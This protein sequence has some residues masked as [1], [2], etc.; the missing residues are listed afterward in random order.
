MIKNSLIKTLNKGCCVFWSKTIKKIME[1]KFQRQ[2]KQIMFRL[3]NWL[4]FA[5]FAD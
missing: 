3:T 1:K 5:Q 4:L 2:K